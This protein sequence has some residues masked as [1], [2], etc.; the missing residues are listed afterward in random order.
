MRLALSLAMIA[1]RAV[2]AETL[3][4]PARDAFYAWHLCAP[5]PLDLQRPRRL[6]STA[7]TAPGPYWK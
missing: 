1:A 6:A 5:R 7:V 2:G 4:A 3:T